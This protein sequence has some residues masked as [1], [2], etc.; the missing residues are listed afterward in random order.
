M[1][2]CNEIPKWLNGE[3][4]KP[5]KYHHLGGIVSLGTYNAYGSLGKYGLFPGGFIKGWFAKLSYNYIYRSH[6]KRIHG[7]CKGYLIWLA[8]RINKFIRPPIRLD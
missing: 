6:Q 1:E 5:F 7:I 8:E 3:E 4:I 2:K